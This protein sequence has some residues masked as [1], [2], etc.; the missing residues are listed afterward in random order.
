MSREIPRGAVRLL[1]REFGGLNIG[2]DFVEWAVQA[3]CDGFD[4]PALRLLAGLDLGGQVSAFE[5]AEHFR[6]ALAELRVDLPDQDSLIRT[7]VREIARDIAD[8]A[9]SP[10]AGVHRIHSEVLAPFDHPA[11]LMS[12]CFLWEGLRP[13]SYDSLDGAALDDVIRQTARAWLK[14][15][16]RGE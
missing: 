12:W 15:T 6:T 4:S 16:S 3:L 5:A 1:V 8:G 11:D 9:L 10:Q 13:G 7:Y 14:D 2:S